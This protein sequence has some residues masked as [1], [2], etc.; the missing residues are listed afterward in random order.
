MIAAGKVNWWIV[1]FGEWC[2]GCVCA[3]ITR[4]ISPDD[5]DD[6][7]HVM[8]CEDGFH[9]LSLLFLLSTTNNINFQWFVE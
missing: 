1:H 5:D 9:L 7:D 6:H 3:D 8:V 4:H 2:V